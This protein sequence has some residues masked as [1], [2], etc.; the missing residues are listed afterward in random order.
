MNHPRAFA[1]SLLGR[2]GDF[3]IFRCRFGL[4]NLIGFACVSRSTLGRVFRIFSGNEVHDGIRARRVL[5]RRL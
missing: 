2:E 4:I 1:N 3:V 5:A